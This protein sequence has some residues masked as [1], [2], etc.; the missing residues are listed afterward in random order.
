MVYV[1]LRC[2]FVQKLDVEFWV[3]FLFI[4]KDVILLRLEMYFQEGGWGE[5]GKEYV[6]FCLFGYKVLNSILK[7][8]VIL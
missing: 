4:K 3:K 1:F 8:Q 6:V 5:K 7:Y 2:F